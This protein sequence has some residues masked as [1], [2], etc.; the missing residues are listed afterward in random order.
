MMYGPTSGTTPLSERGDRD[1]SGSAQAQ[2]NA[3]STHHD[4]AGIG[5]PHEPMRD[6]R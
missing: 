6:D 5:H 4:R 3:A 1:P 2:M